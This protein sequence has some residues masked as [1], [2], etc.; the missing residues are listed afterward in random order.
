MTPK[1]MI[2]AEYKRRTDLVEDI[3]FRKQCVKMAKALGITADEWN[4]EKV[5]IMLIFANKFCQLE[6]QAV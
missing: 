2:K 4:K 1:E 5:H 3:N 6:N